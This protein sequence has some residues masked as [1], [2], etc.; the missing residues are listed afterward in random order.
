MI[1]S[2]SATKNILL[3][4]GTWQTDLEYKS[5]LLVNVKFKTISLYL[6]TYDMNSNHGVYY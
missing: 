5:L 4:H 6:S 3:I 2:K 1:Q